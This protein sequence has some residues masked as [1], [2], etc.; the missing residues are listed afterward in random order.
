MKTGRLAVVVMAAVS[1]GAFSTAPA[2][3]TELPEEPC[4]EAAETA[5]DLGGRPGGERVCTTVDG[6]LMS[7]QSL[8]AVNLAIPV[9][10]GLAEQDERAGG[11][12]T[13]AN[14]RA[15]ES[16]LAAYSTTTE[17]AAQRSADNGRCSISSDP[18]FTYQ[19]EPIFRTN[20]HKEIEDNYFLVLYQKENVHFRPDSAEYTWQVAACQHGGAQWRGNTKAEW[21]LQWYSMGLQNEDTRPVLMEHSGGTGA[22][23]PRLNW[24]ANFG[25]QKLASVGGSVGTTATGYNNFS[26]RASAPGNL[27]SHGEPF[28]SAGRQN[29]SWTWWEHN[30]PWWV[31]SSNRGSTDLQSQGSTSIYEMGVRSSPSSTIRYTGPYW[32]AKCWG[33]TSADNCRA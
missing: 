7:V 1:A 31:P 15:Y 3:A 5:E 11:V 16:A 29:R 25:L 23:E 19:Y 26:Q 2:S 17:S 28:G 4:V 13:M 21:R 14:S 32:L 10:N 30:S 24:S 18:T 9:A 20:G 33:V 12:K 22:D 6:I 27:E 8:P